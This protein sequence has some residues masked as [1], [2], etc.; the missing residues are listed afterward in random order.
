MKS[1]LI[2]ASCILTSLCIVAFANDSLAGNIST[3]S[4]PT[5]TVGL[6]NGN[7]GPKWEYSPA[8]DVLEDVPGGGK[9]INKAIEVVGQLGGQ[10]DITIEELAFD[11]DPFVLNNIQITNNS[12][13]TQIYTVGIALPTVFPA[14]N[15][16]SGN[17]RADVIDG[18]NDGATLASVGAFPLYDAQIDFSSIATLMDPKTIIA[19]IGSSNGEF[20]SFGPSVGGTPVNAAIGIELRFSLTAGDTASILS[21]FDVVEV[22]E[23]NSVALGMLCLVGLV[24]VAVYRR[25]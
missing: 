22:P 17:V 24:G 1:Y 2:G 19:P 14:P 18:N 21:R 23:P 7:G 25:R 16:V 10:T 4:V 12:A 8:L 6:E 15:I 11:P 9:G 5:V 13:M 20:E 3:N